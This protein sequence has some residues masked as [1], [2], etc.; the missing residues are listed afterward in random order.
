MQTGVMNGTTFKFAGLNS[1]TISDIGLLQ[2]ADLS[3][4]GDQTELAPAW[5]HLMILF[6][7]AH[8]L[9]K[10]KREG[11]AS[12]IENIYNNE[13]VYLRQNMVEIIPDARKSLVYQ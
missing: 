4:D 9:H 10:D 1:V 2:E 8:A 5:Q 11:P 3:V 13:L 6:A 12:V 7:T